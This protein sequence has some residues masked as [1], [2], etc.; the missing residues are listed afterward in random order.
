MLKVLLLLISLAQVKDD[1][2]T[3][4]FHTSGAQSVYVAGSF[5]NWSP[6]N[7]QWAMKKVDDTTWMFKKELKPGKYLYKFV[8]NGSEWKDDKDNP[9]KEPDGYGGFNS[10]LIVG[11]KGARA[12]YFDKDGVVFTFADDNAK[13]VYIAGTFNNW[14]S[15]SQPM[16]KENGIWKVKI[17]LA[18]GYYQYKFVVDG[19]KWVPDPLNPA[20]VDDGYGG[21]NSSF[22]LTDDGKVLYETPAKAYE[23]E[24]V[25]G[26]LKKLGTPLYLAIVWHQ[27]QPR[28]YQDLKT[29]EYFAPW[30]RLHGIKDYFDMAHIL[31]NYPNV[32][33]TINLTPVLL[34]QLENEIKMY[35][36]GKSPDVEV[37]M[38]L[39]NA[40][41][42]T[43]ED[44]KHLLSSFFS[45]NWD[46]MID[47]WPRYRE[48]RLKRVMNPDGSINFEKTMKRYT[49]QD[50]RDLQMWF[51]LAWFD[52]DFQEGEVTLP[53]GKTV[54]VKKYIEQGRN[55]TEKQ[56]KEVMDI[57]FEILKAIIPEHKKLQ[58][59]GQIEVITT[60]YYH[61]ILPLIYDTDLAKEAMPNT[62][63][64]PRFS[65]PSDAMWHLKKAVMKYESIFGR[66]P[67]GMWP[68]EGSVAEAI[69]PLVHDAGFKWMASDVGV[70]SRSLNKGLLQADDMYRPYVV[71][72]KDKTVYM[73]F[74][75]T[76][77]SDRI[78]FRYRSLS[79]VAA[80]ND[81]IKTLYEIHK[82]FADDPQPHLVTVILDGENA[83]EW[84]KRDA[85]DFFH[86]L[87][88][89]LDS[90]DWLITTTVYDFL[91]KYPPKR[92]INHLFAGSWINADFSTWIGEPE[93]NL[94]WDY[95][96]RV[97]KWFEKQ[98]A[99]GKYEK[100]V[101]DRAFMELASAEGS[102]WFWFF[103]NDQNAPGGDRWTDVMFRR[104]LKNV[105]QILGKPYPAFLDSTILNTSYTGASSGGGIMAKNAVSLIGAELYF[106]EKDRKGDDYGD[107]N[108]SYPQNGVFE[109]G[110]FDLLGM[111]VYKDPKGRYILKFRFAKLGNPWA[112]PYGFSFPF[113]HFYI[114]SREGS[115]KPFYDNINVVFD[116]PYK[117][118]VLVCGWPEHT[119]I[120]DENGRKIQDVDVSVDK[121]DNAILVAFPESVVGEIEG[122]YVLVLSYDGY[123]KNGIRKVT[124]RGGEWEIGGGGKNAPPVLDILDPSGKQKAYLSVW[125]EGKTPEIRAFWIHR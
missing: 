63:L 30:V 35:E 117:Y 69:V 68:A 39:K 4:V 102:D 20:K 112:A 61:P 100:V 19:T 38:T 10:V 78:G 53:T 55:F 57:E 54:S 22:K 125:R 46:N 93:E 119:G 44:K 52:P 70:L 121:K 110:V 26:K 41:S 88:S 3:F 108:Y 97:R 103:G 87:Y 101:L 120:Y 77:L 48:L 7:P 84:Y 47:I 28:Y 51:N 76:D 62:P 15:K 105:Y 34:M 37:R 6:N 66:K 72:K 40:D 32:H 104:T 31:E 81:F 2:V 123:G 25:M 83:W 107:G 8:I 65:W 58:D 111:E 21:F 1:S 49:T 90:S 124:K 98:K 96:G 64:P 18:P 23:N 89:Q 29:G 43:V 99:S 12:P 80:A 118:A 74:R 14:D 95:L 24:P 16:K 71:G 75:D 45:A 56:K 94:A 109:K 115:K 67:Y 106:K 85:K 82:K 13:S 86:A 27:H 59:M 116:R 113:I 42:L 5:N 9:L 33:V 79:G 17:K 73:V 60:P 114:M 91:E 11:A 122:G 50:Y 36:E 92:H